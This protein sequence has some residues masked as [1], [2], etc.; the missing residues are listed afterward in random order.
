MGDVSTT[1]PPFAINK[2][3]ISRLLAISVAV[4]STSNTL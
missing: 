3:I 2:R 1:L 4:L